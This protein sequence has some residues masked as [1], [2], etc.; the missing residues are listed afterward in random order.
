MRV[1]CVET[2]ICDPY[3]QYF[4]SH[5]EARKRAVQRIRDFVQ[6]ERKY[7]KS[8]RLAEVAY[9]LSIQIKACTVAKAD[10]QTIVTLLNKD[11]LSMEEQVVEEWNPQQKWTKH[12]KQR[13]E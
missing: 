12:N 10:K 6:E 11:E 9:D 3:V 7:N 8:F 13:G 2:N 5:V 1:Y 4:R